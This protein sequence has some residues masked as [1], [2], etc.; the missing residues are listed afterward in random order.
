MSSLCVFCVVCRTDKDVALLKQIL[1]RVTAKDMRFYEYAKMLANQQLAT[2]H[3]AISR[4]SSFQNT[5]R[6]RRL[7]R[8]DASSYPSSSQEAQDSRQHEGPFCTSFTSQ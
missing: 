3:A 5:H 8:S 6:G 2:E 4:Y 7:G 1:S